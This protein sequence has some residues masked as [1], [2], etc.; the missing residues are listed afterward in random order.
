MLLVLLLLLLLLLF[1]HLLLLLLLLF[2]WSRQLLSHGRHLLGTENQGLTR[3]NRLQP[4]SIW[5]NLSFSEY[6]CISQ[7]I[8][9]KN[10]F[11]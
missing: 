9:S 6:D 11:R 4:V 5:S 10:R 2:G 8:C 7:V 1:L 3:L